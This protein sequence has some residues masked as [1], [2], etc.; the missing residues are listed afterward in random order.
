MITEEEFQI[1]KAEVD[2][3]QIQASEK[4]KP[5]ISRPSNII[6][7]FA[8]LF[9]FGTTAFSFWKSHNEAIA[10]NRSEVRQLIQRITRLPIENFDLTLKY[11]DNAQGQQLTSMIAQEQLLLA[12]QAAEKINLFPDSFTSTE[13]F[14]VAGALANVNSPIFVPKFLQ[15]SISLAN[16]ANDYVVA[17]RSYGHFLFTQGKI[18]EGRAFY[19][20]ALNE[21]WSKFPGIDRF[22]RK[23]L[24]IQT[25]LNLANSENMIGNYKEALKA[26]SE[27]QSVTVELPNSQFRDF[28]QSQ[29]LAVKNSIEQGGGPN[30]PS[31][32]APGP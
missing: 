31:A 4:H 12:N 32:I 24:V 26:V 3:L 30:A 9:S 28:W 6:S 16:T 18:D 5:W 8:L 11:K 2:T 19:S 25:N 27:A 21:T 17:S 13:Y 20:K 1:L 23:G 22:Y 29:V 15:R 10:N 7:L 14:A